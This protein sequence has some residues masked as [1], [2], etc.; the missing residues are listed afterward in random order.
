MCQVS[1]VALAG[2]DAWEPRVSVGERNGRADDEGR[3][4]PVV[5]DVEY[6]PWCQNPDVWGIPGDP[7]GLDGYA[8]NLR[9]KAADLRTYL[10]DIQRLTPEWDGEAAEVF[11]ELKATLPPRMELVAERFDT[12]ADALTGYA[13]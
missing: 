5:G 7:D 13:E 3:R 9:V 8:G 10:D 2:A 4:A 6:E 12:V 1:H 11:M